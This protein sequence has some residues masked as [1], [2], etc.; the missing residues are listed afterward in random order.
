MRGVCKC[1]KA[2]VGFVCTWVRWRFE[3]I[4]AKCITSSKN[5][6]LYAISDPLFK[7]LVLKGNC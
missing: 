6:A 7:C 1:W 5:I 2:V 4:S 3:E